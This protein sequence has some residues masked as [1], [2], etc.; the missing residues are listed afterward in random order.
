GLERLDRS[1]K[2][3]DLR[4]RIR[5]EVLEIELDACRIFVCGHQLDGFREEE[6]MGTVPEACAL[7]VGGHRVA[8][9][10]VCIGGPIETIVV[11]DDELAVAKELEVDLG[12]E[13][14]LGVAPAPSRTSTAI[15]PVRAGSRS[16]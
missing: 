12:T 4:P 13:D 1:D 3:L 14:V 16:R 10:A 6:R 5:S 7:R 11:E 8:D 9:Q 15:Q 2:G